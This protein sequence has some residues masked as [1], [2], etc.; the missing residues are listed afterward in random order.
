MTKQTARQ[1]KPRRP[2]GYRPRLVPNDAGRALGEMI[3]MYADGDIELDEIAR[4]M[5]AA[6]DTAR[7]MEDNARSVLDVLHEQG[8]I[9][10]DMHRRLQ[11]AVAG[12]SGT[13]VMSTRER[14]EEPASD[15]EFVEDYT[16]SKGD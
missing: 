10:D 6:G 2:Y 3:K 11:S 14:T 5:N 1:D 9:D 8:E 12:A 13:Y 16:S 4:V 7:T 15:G